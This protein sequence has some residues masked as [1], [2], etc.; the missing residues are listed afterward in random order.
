MYQYSTFS[1]FLFE[2]SLLFPIRPLSSVFIRYLSSSQLNLFL[3]IY[4]KIFYF[5]F[6]LFLFFLSSAFFFNLFTR[7]LFLHHYSTSFLYPSFP[8]GFTLPG[9]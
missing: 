2:I 7:Q 3:L 1:L 8:L 5:L 4:T 9:L 6:A